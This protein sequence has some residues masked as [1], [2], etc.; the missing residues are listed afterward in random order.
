M[1]PQALSEWLTP[2]SA[3]ERNGAL[4]TIYSALTVGTRQ[5]FW[6]EMPTGKE[7]AIIKM[8]HGVN[9]LHHTLASQLMACVEDEEGYALESFDRQLQ[10]IANQ[11][12]I[13]G[14][15]AQAVDFARTRNLASKK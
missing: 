13:G 2:L 8:L 6:P 12:G 14:L 3:S 1:E 4:A 9:E 5:L 15:L 11:Y 10:E 7:Q